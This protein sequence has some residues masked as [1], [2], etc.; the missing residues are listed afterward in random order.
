[1]SASE[2]LKALPNAYLE[3]SASVSP[4]YAETWLA[5]TVRTALPQIMALAEAAERSRQWAQ[6]EILEG[7]PELGLIDMELTTALDDLEK[8]LP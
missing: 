5:Q 3:R 8:A 4:Q 7:P 1:M 6:D 2:K